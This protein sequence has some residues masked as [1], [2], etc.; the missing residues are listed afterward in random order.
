MATEVSK[1]RMLA[2]IGERSSATMK[3]IGSCTPAM[4]TSSAAMRTG[5]L[6]IGAPG[7]AGGEPVGAGPTPS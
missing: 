1:V 3:M 2:S 6:R 5:S 7:W 4:R